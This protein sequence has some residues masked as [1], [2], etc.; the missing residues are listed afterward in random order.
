MKFTCHDLLDQKIVDRVILEK[1]KTNEQIALELQEQL[2]VQL[3]YWMKKSK[4]EIVSRRLER[5]NQY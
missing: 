4:V 5:F 1:K 3:D 2:K